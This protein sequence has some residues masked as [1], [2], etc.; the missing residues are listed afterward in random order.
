MRKLQEG[1]LLPE[2]PGHRYNYP[3]S[4]YRN[5]KQLSYPPAIEATVRR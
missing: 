3:T 4:L 5:T 2:T 1:S